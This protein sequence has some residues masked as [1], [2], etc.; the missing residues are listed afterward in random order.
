M[1]GNGW[2]AT[3][4]DHALDAAVFGGILL[5]GVARLPASFAG[6]QALNML[7]G[8]VIAHGGAPYVD[9]WDLKYPGIFFFFA[10]GGRLFGFNEIGIH[11]FELLWMLGLALAVRITAGHYLR[12]RTAASL[13]PALTVGFYYASA[14]V[15]L[16]T[17]TEALVGL[18]L[19]LSLAF[20]A[21]AVRPGCRQ[22]L[23]WLS[24]SGLSAGVVMV[25]KAPYV[26]LPGIFWLLALAE[27]RRASGKGIMT[28]VRNMAP[29]FLAGVLV[30][31]SATI[32][33][34]AQKH[35]LGIAWW[36]FV[37]HPREAAT[38]TV[39]DSQRLVDS[40]M[41]FLQTFSLPLALA[42]VGAWDRLRR[43]LDLLTAG[44]LAWMG[45]GA[46][47]IWLQVISWWEYQYL[48]LLVPTGLLAA[49]GV[50]TL[51][52][53]VAATL[54]PRQRRSA[55]LAVLLGM[56]VLSVPQ[57]DL[58]ARSF[59]SIL[60]ARPEP[61]NSRSLRVYEA[62]HDQDYADAVQTTSFLQE[63]GSYAGP[64]YVF[65]NPILYYVAGRA[66]AV[67]LLA[68]WFHPTS[69]L[70]QRLTADL[71]GSPPPYILISEPAMESIIGYNPAMQDNVSALR[72]WVEQRYQLLRTD[73][74]GTW[75]VRRDL[76][77]S[78]APG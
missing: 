37:V 72:S 11:L 27:W 48:L 52:S 44:L 73:V 18:P 63:R 77:G 69:E 40:S 12:S 62:L 43:G 16:L 15:F 19:L 10:A 53:A 1:V 70:W 39:L 78:A 26:V 75:Y 17:Q 29:P 34:L 8:R 54:A 51:W 41:W 46:L 20:V 57:V 61:L 28:G 76:A 74:G 38:E 7:M 30:P 22:P 3:A 68:P 45:V 64:I 35:A 56:T 50:E 23:A 36:T 24:A 67:P 58:A 6:D 47:L 31:V 13:A 42:V 25:F 33:Y 55:I 4:R 5:L 2:K 9:L 49:Q 60:R 14:T 21:A 59:A 71:A 65:G 32:I 66:P